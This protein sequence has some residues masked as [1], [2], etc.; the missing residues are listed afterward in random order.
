MMV[1]RTYVA[2]SRVGKVAITVYVSPERRQE[3]KIMAAQN[4]T[5]IQDIIDAAIEK[6][7]KRGRK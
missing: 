1:D 2:P 5:S 7:V 3:L 6:E 4:V